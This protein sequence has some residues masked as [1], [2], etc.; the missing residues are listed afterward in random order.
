MHKLCSLPSVKSV[1]SVLVACV[2]GPAGL[3]LLGTAL[4]LPM[5]AATETFS[6]FPSYWF[7]GLLATTAA[8][9]VLATV[10]FVV[11]PIFTEPPRGVSACKVAQAAFAV[12][13]VSAAALIF[14]FVIV[15]AA[16]VFGGALF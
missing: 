2:L 5:R 13:V 11:H 16:L 14:E 15:L 7:G 10:I 9:V 4:Y 1:G 3:V 8:V 12:F 6:R